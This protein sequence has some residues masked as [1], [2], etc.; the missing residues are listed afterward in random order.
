MTTYPNG[1]PGEYPI[2]AGTDR[3]ALR[4]LL[5]DTTSVAYSPAQAGYQN[6]TYFS[7]LELDSFLDL[8][9]D[10]VLGA[11]G[12]AYLS[13]AASATASAKSITDHDLKIDTTKRAAEYRALAD[14]YLGQAGLNGGPEYF[15]VVSTGR[16][17][18]ATEL[19]TDVPADGY[20]PL[21][22]IALNNLG[23]L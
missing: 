7:D 17:Y 12:Y 21:D 19:L 1:N 14:L 4:S 9:G 2:T 5:S 23:L 20:D 16:K 6:Y 13:L 22:Y 3:A 10:S 8:A 18:T 15:E 11:A